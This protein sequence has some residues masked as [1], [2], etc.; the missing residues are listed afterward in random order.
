MNE[1]S[2]EEHTSDKEEEEAEQSI[3][4]VFS[5]ALNSENKIVFYLLRAAGEKDR[6]MLTKQAESILHLVVLNENI[7]ALK[8]LINEC[9]VD[10]NLQDSDG[11]TPLHLAYCI[12]AVDIIEYLISVGCEQDI[13]NLS[14]KLPAQMLDSDS[15]EE[16]EIEKEIVEESEEEE[17][18]KEE[19]VEKPEDTTEIFDFFEFLPDEIIYLIV[20][21]LFPRDV[22][23]LRLMNSR[24]NSIAQDPMTWFTVV[25]LFLDSD[26]SSNRQAYLLI[27][28]NWIR[29]N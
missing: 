15:E 8:F 20:C 7:A 6:E 5:A 26:F 2:D 4:P 21:N 24:L 28:K 9:N 11:N 12:D 23:H 16:N 19:I 3:T 1:Q 25:F 10:I 17:P 27:I 22:C 29:I 14:G 13:T 18:I